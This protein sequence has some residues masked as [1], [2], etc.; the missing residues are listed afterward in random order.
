MYRGHAPPRS[1]KVRRRPTTTPKLRIQRVLSASQQPLIPSSPS[2]SGR[3][4]LFFMTKLTDSPPKQLLLDE[5]ADSA[6]TTMWEDEATTARTS[7][8]GDDD[9]DVA[10][11]AVGDPNTL[12]DEGSDDRKRDN[13]DVEGPAACEIERVGSLDAD[14]AESE[15]PSMEGQ[16]GGFYLQWQQQMDT[17]QAARDQLEADLNQYLTTLATKQDDSGATLVEFPDN[18]N[19]VLKLM[20][21]SDVENASSSNWSKALLQDGLTKKQAFG[22]IAGEDVPDEMNVKIAHGIA[23]IRQLDAMLDELDKKGTKSTKHQPTKPFMVASSKKSTSVQR[24]K[25]KVEAAKSLQDANSTYELYAEVHELNDSSFSSTTTPDFIQRNKEM[26]EAGTSLT[27]SE[28]ARLDSLINDGDGTEPSNTT[29]EN[30]F[31]IDTGDA[32]DSSLKELLAKRREDSVALLTPVPSFAH[33]DLSQRLLAIDAALQTFRDEEGG[34]DNDDDT[35]S[36]RSGVSG[37]SSMWSRASTRTVSKQDI[38]IITHRAKQEVLETEKAPP[39]AIKQLL[40]TLAGITIEIVDDADGPEDPSTEPPQSAPPLKP[41]PPTQPPPRRKSSTAASKPPNPP[42]SSFSHLF[43]LPFEA[44]G[45]R[46]QMINPT[47]FR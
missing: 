18:Y 24:I 4:E 16:G 6:S 28:A 9:D 19:D 5:T 20:T 13:Q 36:M 17:A 12:D 8:S 47:Q 45:P 2:K 21:K 11:R 43:T 46:K 42:T 33:L 34:D 26:K 41:E 29:V 7:D 35:M 37:S 15:S 38:S 31:G 1:P 10:E 22:I 14:A 3:G 25:D 27:K 39:E 23:Q 32:I 44:L 30:P 40:A